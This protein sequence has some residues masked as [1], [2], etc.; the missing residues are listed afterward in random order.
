MA[1]WNRTIGV[2]LGCALLASATGAF[3]QD[4][5][6]WRGANRDGKAAGFEAPQTWPGTLEAKWRTTVG[7]RRRH[8][9]PG[10]RQALRLHAARGGRSDPLPGG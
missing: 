10:G 5:P 1:I 4:W 3:A 9:G 2:V 6:Q 8:A 7:T